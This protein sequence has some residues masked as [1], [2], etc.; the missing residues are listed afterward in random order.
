MDSCINYISLLYFIKKWRNIFQTSIFYYFFS[1]IPSKFLLNIL[2]LFKSLD[3][4]I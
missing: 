4:E 2:A 3:I 1:I